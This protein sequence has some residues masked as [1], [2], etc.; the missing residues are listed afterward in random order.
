MELIF[1]PAILQVEKKKGLDSQRV[2]SPK[3]VRSPT[4]GVST[5]TGKLPPPARLEGQ[6]KGSVRC[7]TDN[8]T[9]EYSVPNQPKLQSHTSFHHLRTSIVPVEG[10]LLNFRACQSLSWLSGC[11]RNYN[12]LS[13]KGWPA[14]IGRIQLPAPALCFQPAKFATI[15]PIQS[16][17]LHRVPTAIH[18]YPAHPAVIRIALQQL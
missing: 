10:V 4:V 7:V 18:T 3:V 12:Y 14:F 15:R 1:S 6:R 16:T 8:L 9:L 13:Q 17:A 5:R 2:P 11:F